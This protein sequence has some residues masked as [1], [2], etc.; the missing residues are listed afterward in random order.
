MRKGEQN[1]NRTQGP[2][3]LP[4]AVLHSPD[5]LPSDQVLCVRLNSIG[6]KILLFS[7]FVLFVLFLQLTAIST[8]TKY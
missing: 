7:V 3:Q 4:G 5:C 8:K 6:F 1:V 2:R